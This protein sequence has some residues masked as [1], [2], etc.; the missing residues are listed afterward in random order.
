VTPYTAQAR[1]AGLLGAFNPNMGRYDTRYLDPEI[2]L[3]SDC[4]QRWIDRNFKLDYLFKSIEKY[5]RGDERRRIRLMRDVIKDFAFDLLGMMISLW[6]RPVPAQGVR[7]QFPGP[8]SGFGALDD[9]GKSMLLREMMDRHFEEMTRSMR[10]RFAQV[11]P[12]LPDD[13]QHR[14]LVELE[15]WAAQDDWNQINEF[16]EPGAAS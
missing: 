1:A 11:R 5:T 16:K 13:E 4:A 8:R 15:I 9:H 14:I 12:A 10:V 6:D 7:S 3:F 2:G